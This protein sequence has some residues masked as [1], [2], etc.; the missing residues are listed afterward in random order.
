VNRNWPPEL[1][2]VIESLF[3]DEHLTSHL[4]DVEA[5]AFYREALSL[6]LDHFALGED[7]DT[8]I[9][10]ILHLGQLM[11]EGYEWRIALNKAFHSHGKE[12]V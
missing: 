8:L 5:E 7:E 11:D 10:R 1:D 6:I 4:T 2:R 12:E 3:E 9:D